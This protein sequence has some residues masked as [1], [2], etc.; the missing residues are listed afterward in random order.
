[1]KILRWFNC[2]EE[3]HYITD[4]SKE[5]RAEFISNNERSWNKTA[6]G[7]DCRPNFISELA[8]EKV[9]NFEEK[10]IFKN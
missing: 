1:M 4:C 9:E 5:N 7:W 6:K 3:G 10:N 8:Q 2:I